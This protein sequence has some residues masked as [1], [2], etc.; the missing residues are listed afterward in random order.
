LYYASF[1][2]KARLVTGLD[3]LAKR[4]RGGYSDIPS[5]EIDDSN[6]PAACRYHL[7]LPNVA[8]HAPSRGA[9]E[10]LDRR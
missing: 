3:F 8:K 9:T 7:E 10:G 2:F 5:L 1:R 4:L 6:L